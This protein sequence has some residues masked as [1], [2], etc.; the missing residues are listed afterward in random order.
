M[1]IITGVNGK[2][3]I[4]ASEVAGVTD[5]Q[6]NNEKILLEAEPTLGGT[7]GSFIETATSSKKWSGQFTVLYDKTVF[8]TLYNAYISNT[9]VALELIP[10]EAA[11]EIVFSG[12]AHITSAPI[13]VSAGAIVKCT[14]NFSGNGDLTFAPNIAITPAAGAL[15]AQVGVS[16]TAATFAASGGNDPY[17]YTISGLVPGL[18]LNASSGVYNGTPIAGCQGTYRIRITATDDDGVAFS[19][20]YTVVVAA[21]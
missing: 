2:V 9:T 4:A 10:K 21:A 1:A 11:G 6:L 14:C 15:A 5:F 20:D 19:Q 13:T 18:S 3:S 12:N 7:E 17:T 16:A 8:T